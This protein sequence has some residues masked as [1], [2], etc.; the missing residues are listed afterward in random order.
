MTTLKYIVFEPKFISYHTSLVGR[1]H[2]NACLYIMQNITVIYMIY[3]LC[4]LGKRET[5][6]NIKTS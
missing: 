2:G 4:V 3:Y 5:T 6:Q 1:Y